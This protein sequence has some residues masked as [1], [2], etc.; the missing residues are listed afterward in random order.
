MRI[1]G[2]QLQRGSSQF[3]GGGGGP[4]PPHRVVKQRKGR[5]CAGVAAQEREREREKEGAAQSIALR[6]QSVWDSLVQHTDAAHD[7]NHACTQCSM[8]MCMPHCFSCTAGIFSSSLTS[9][10][11]RFTLALCPYHRARLQQLKMLSLGIRTALAAV[12]LLLCA[13]SAPLA[14]TAAS[15]S[16][17]SES[18][19]MAY[20]T[21]ATTFNCL[22]LVA[23][24]WMS[25]E[26]WRNSAL[27]SK[28][29]L[30]FVGQLGGALIFVGSYFP[31][32]VGNLARGSL[33]GPSWCRA[34]TMLASASIFLTSASNALIR[35]G[36]TH[37][38]TNQRAQSS[39]EQRARRRTAA[40]PLLL[41]I[42]HSLTASLHSFFFFCCAP[43]VLLLAC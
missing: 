9:S 42:S 30:V 41:L 4:P 19:Q 5:R 37:T 28:G 16:F 40:P 10:L 12:G 3:V 33:G 26:Y 24:T 23:L 27:H 35:S 15:I 1:E 36:N 43:A 8:L 14:V 2:N 25:V 32:H 39:T 22:S 20:W 11:T 21:G 6:W 31:Y 18:E 34:A 38:H 7:A 13:A 29:L 17:A